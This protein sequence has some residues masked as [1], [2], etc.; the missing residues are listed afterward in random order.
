[1]GLSHLQTRS[2]SKLSSTTLKSDIASNY[3]RAP[4]FDNVQV[5]KFKSPAKR[6]S[7]RTIVIDGQNVAVEH[8]KGNLTNNQV[9]LHV[10]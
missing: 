1:M 4:N 6:G 9:L 8:A 10:I 5:D 3:S 7:L 2:R